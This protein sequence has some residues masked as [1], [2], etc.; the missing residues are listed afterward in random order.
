L[1]N[2]HDF[3]ATRLPDG[4]WCTSKSLIDDWIIQLWRAKK[5]AKAESV[6]LNQ[7]SPST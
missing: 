1:V 3:P 7:P 2:Q 6:P 5:T 4:R